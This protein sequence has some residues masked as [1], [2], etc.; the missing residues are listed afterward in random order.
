M[1]SYKQSKFSYISRVCDAGRIHRKTWANS[2]KNLGEFTKVNLGEIAPGRIH[3][4][5][6]PHRA[7]QE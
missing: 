7:E 6:P 2:P 3:R 4:H 1:K 5:S